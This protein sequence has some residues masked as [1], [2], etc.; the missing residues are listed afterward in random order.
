MN[1]SLL[2]TRLRDFLREEIFYD[3]A[4]ASNALQ[5]D[6]SLVGMLSSLDITRLVGFC[7]ES[8][9]IEIPNTEIIPE[10]FES[11]GSMVALLGRLGA[12]S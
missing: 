11:I 6:D 7:E 10:H 12:G 5:K 9:A 4:L 2:E 3:K 8:F 1:E